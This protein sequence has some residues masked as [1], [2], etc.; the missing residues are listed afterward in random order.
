MASR[1]DAGNE[2]V[3]DL[4]PIRHFLPVSGTSIARD[5]ISH[6]SGYAPLARRY[7]DDGQQT[8]KRSERSSRD[9]PMFNL[10]EGR[11]LL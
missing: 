2:L 1:G 3:G 5:S 9:P 4:R 10:R 6:P 7:D 11:Q 8:Q